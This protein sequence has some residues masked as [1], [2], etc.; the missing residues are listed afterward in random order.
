[1]PPL[2]P[3]DAHWL[4]AK[5]SAAEQRTARGLCVVDRCDGRPTMRVCIV[6]R[7]GTIAGGYT[8]YSTPHRACEY[9]I[10]RASVAVEDVLRADE[11]ALLRARAHV[12]HGWEIEGVTLAVTGALI[13]TRWR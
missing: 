12:E 2:T 8:T 9:H 13:M 11:A 3:A 10:D 5:C 1:M 4:A 7:P 6:A